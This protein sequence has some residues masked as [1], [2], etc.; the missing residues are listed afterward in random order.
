SR[1]YFLGAVTTI[2][3]CTNPPACSAGTLFRVRHRAHNAPSRRRGEWVTNRT[4]ARLGWSLA[5]LS[6]TFVA[7][8]MVLAALSGGQTNLDFNGPFFAAAIVTFSVLGALL[9]SRRPGN[10][11]G[12]IFLAASTAFALSLLADWSAHY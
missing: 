11:F 5:G 9:A 12:W 4:A 1:A 10:P 6:T 3:V 2:A 7:A 8:A